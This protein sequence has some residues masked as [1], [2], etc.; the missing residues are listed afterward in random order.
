LASAEASGCGGGGNRCCVRLAA[1]I[2][3]RARHGPCGSTAAAAA[4]WRQQRGGGSGGG[5]SGSAA[6]L[7]RDQAVGRIRIARREEAL[8]HQVDAEGRAH[9]TG[10]QRAERAFHLGIPGDELG[11]RLDVEGR[12]GFADQRGVGR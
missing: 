10:R 8:A 12:E 1:T 11:P 9:L 7:L 5:S 6:R 3:A 2:T 4:G